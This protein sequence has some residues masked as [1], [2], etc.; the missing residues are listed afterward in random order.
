M[1]PVSPLG[2]RSAVMVILITPAETPLFIPCQQQPSNLNE[3]NKTDVHALIVGHP[4][5]I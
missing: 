2:R 5:L 3:S 4:D 1:T